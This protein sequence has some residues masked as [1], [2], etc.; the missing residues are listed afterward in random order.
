MDILGRARKMERRIARSVD[1]AVGELVG[2]SSPGALEIV[3]AVVEQAEQRVQE[4]GRGRRVFPFNRVVVH[5]LAPAGDREARARFN[6]VADGPPSL[7][8]RI[9]ER[10][11]GLGCRC[12]DLSVHVTF[13]ASAGA[14]WAAPE[15][16]A[17]FDKVT[18]KSAPV[19][20]SPAPVAPLRLKLTVAAGEA[21]RRAFVFEGERVDIGRGGEVMDAKQRIARTNHVAFVEEGEGVNRTVSRRHA[22]LIYVPS[23]PEY[24]ICDD[25]SV[26]GTALV[27]NGR[28][29]PVPPGPRGVRVQHGDEVVL[30]QARLRVT[31]EPATSSAAPP[32][33]D[34][35]PPPRRAR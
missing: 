33:A 15:F 8:D 12:D 4:A 26:H 7:A 1:A 21:S 28:T 3:H 25:R 30:G 9:R 32:P 27:R 2:R 29:I 13:S 5:V 16:H 34:P 18:P 17:D 10:V 24:R 11:Q 35:E 22:H 19:A 14:S 6:A 23:P 20:E 31:L